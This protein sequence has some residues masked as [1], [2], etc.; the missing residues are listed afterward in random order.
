MLLLFMFFYSVLL[1]Y[2]GTGLLSVNQ[3]GETTSYYFMKHFS[4][5]IIAIVLIYV[6]QMIHYR[7]IAPFA[8][9]LLWASILLLAVALVFGPEINQS[10]RWLFVA[11]ISFQPSDFAKFTLTIYVAQVLATHTDDLSRAFVKIMAYTILVTGLIIKSNL[12]TAGLIFVGIYGLMF[13]GRIPLKYLGGILAMLVLGG[14]VFFAIVIQ[15]SA[16]NN[17]RSSTWE[18]RIERFFDES[19]EHEQTKSAKAAISTGGFF[20]KGTGKSTERVF[21][22]H[23]YSDFVF[24]LMIEEWGLLLGAIPL[25][26]F[27]LILIYRVIV[28]VR[29]LDRAF[30]AFLVIGLTL[31]ILLQALLNMFV[32]VDLAPVTGQPLP[33]ISMGGTAMLFTAASLGTILSVSRFYNTTDEQ[34]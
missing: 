13:V 24:A 8:K 26:L 14:A 6:L 25:I 3:Y 34:Q 10:N 28:L 33:F 23:S 12:S 18:K 19:K 32:S 5:W 16:D 22:S 9:Y 15:S 29:K 4:I 7:Y 30:P 27:Y 17:G 31:N 1:V 11:G 20:G 2:S 21:L